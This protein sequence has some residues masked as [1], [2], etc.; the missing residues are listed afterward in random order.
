MFPS[1]TKLASV[2]G[3]GGGGGTGKSVYFENW[4]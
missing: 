3:G 2:L 1:I 4:F